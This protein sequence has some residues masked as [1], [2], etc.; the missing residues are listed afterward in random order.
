[1][2]LIYL[3][4]PMRIVKVKAHNEGVYLN[5][6]Q[7]YEAEFSAL[8]RKRPGADGRFSLDT[9]LG[10]SVTGFILE[11]DAIPAGIAAIAARPESVYEVCEFYVVPSFRKQGWGMR[12]AHELWRK[13]PGAWEVKQIA[14]AGYATL[15]W[16]KAIEDFGYLACSEETFNDPYW[17]EVTRQC[18][19][20]S[21]QAV[22]ANEAVL[23]S[24]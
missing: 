7:G 4:P 8:T 3:C 21:A 6:A 19:V 23:F 24:P 5:L 13:H 15:F 20:V 1:M 2:Y 22:A 18:F 14:G 9:L 16:R 11:I 12:F 10:D 17:G